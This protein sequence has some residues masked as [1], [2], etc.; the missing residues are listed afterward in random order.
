[1]RAR[2]VGRDGKKFFVMDNGRKVLIFSCIG[3]PDIDYHKTIGSGTRAR[4]MEIRT[5]PQGRRL[6]NN[7]KH[8]KI[9]LEGSAPLGGENPLLR[10]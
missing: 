2:E 3:P 4:V 7:C 8:I 1:M 10:P 6:P 9:F 5:M